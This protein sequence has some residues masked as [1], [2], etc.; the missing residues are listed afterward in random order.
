[1]AAPVP[2][3][4]AGMPLLLLDS[5][6]SERLPVLSS[7]AFLLSS[8]LLLLV[9][10]NEGFN[11]EGTAGAWGEVE[12]GECDGEAGRSAVVIDILALSNGCGDGRVD[13]LSLDPGRDASRMV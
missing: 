1:M 4:I 3:T 2:A 7:L 9:L 10:E 12:P 6:C 8:L 11:G 5:G 13:V